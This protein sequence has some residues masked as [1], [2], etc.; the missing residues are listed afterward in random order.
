MTL[1]ADAF[2]KFPM[3]RL[4]SIAEN[5][6]NK[7]IKLPTETINSIHF[8]VRRCQFNSITFVS[9]TLNNLADGFGFGHYYPDIIIFTVIIT[10]GKETVLF[11]FALTLKETL[12]LVNFF[13]LGTVM[14][15]SNNTLT[16]V[17]DPLAGK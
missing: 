9:F 4:F 14:F 6:Y 7:S 11:L 5:R 8:I 10:T 13:C 16:L 15:S 17:L 2:W 12:L 1:R 3:C